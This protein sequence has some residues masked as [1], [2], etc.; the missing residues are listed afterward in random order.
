MKTIEEINQHNV[1]KILTEK[2]IPDFFP[3]DVIKVGVRI[4]EGKKDRIQYFEGVCI[5]RKNRDIN[6]SFTVRKISFGEGVERTFPLYGTVIDTI[7]VIR[8]GKVRRAK[9]YYLRDRT[10][11]SARIAEK[12]RKKIGIEVD[13]KPETVT[14]ETLAPVAV[15]SEKQTEV[16]AEPVKQAEVQAE[17]KIEKTEEKK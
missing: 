10:G 7:T 17:P 9:L 3:G 5:A 12:I 14:E 4:T 15:E 6:S 8:H 16:Q 1:K 13:V 11:K 2:K